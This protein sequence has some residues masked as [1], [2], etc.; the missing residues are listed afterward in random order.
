MRILIAAGGTGGHIYPALAVLRSLAQRQPDLEVRW[1]GGRRGLGVGDASRRRGYRARPALAALAAHRRPVR[2]TRC[3]TRSGSARRCPRRWHAGPM[4]SGR[5][6]HHGRLRRHPG[7]DRRPRRCASR[8]CCG[9]ATGSPAAACGPRRG[10]RAPSR[11]A[12][13]RPPP[14]CRHRATSRARPSAHFEGID[15]AAARDALRPAAGPAG[16]ARVRW[17]AGRAALQRGRGRR[18]PELVE[19][20]H[21]DPRHR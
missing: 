14:R 15:R 16:G 19:P 3:S 8:R 13:Q 4:A 5:G 1:L 9:R 11:S 21:R 6:L 12:S 20:G 2:R 17:L 18:P 7:V 10:W